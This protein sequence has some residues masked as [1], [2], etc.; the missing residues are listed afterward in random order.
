MNLLAHLHLGD[1]LSS[2]AAVAG[3]LLADY[4]RGSGGGEFGEGVRLHREIDS[5]TDNH[6][7]VAEA[8]SLFEG[9]YRRFGGVLADLAFDHCLMLRWDEWSPEIQCAT[10]I[11]TRLERVLGT[12]KQLPK[13]ALLVVRKMFQEG[14]LHRYSQIEGIGNSIARI[15]SRRPVAKGLQGGEQQIAAQLG[16][17]LEIF[18]AFYPELISH[19]RSVIGGLKVRDND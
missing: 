18:G 11:D 1:G 12:G 6:R 7:L 13:S 3:N 10:F 14:W 5:F 16:R 17:L 19:S 9:E 2:T 4:C 15:A 8:R